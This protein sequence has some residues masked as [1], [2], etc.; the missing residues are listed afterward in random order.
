M[1]K[2]LNIFVSISLIF[3]V[4]CVETE[5]KKERYLIINGESLD[6]SRLSVL[7]DTVD[8]RPLGVENGKKSK[9]L[10]LII[11][12]RLDPPAVEG[13][14]LM[15]TCVS[16]LRGGFVASYNFRGEP[17]HGSLD[18]VNSNLKLHSQVIFNDLDAHAVCVSDAVN[19]KVYIAGASETAEGASLGTISLSGNE[20]FVEDFEEVSLGS[21]AATSV[22]ETDDL[23]FVTTGNDEND[24][25]GLYLFD[26][27][28][29]QLAYEPIHDAR[30]VYA[31]NEQVFVM[32][33]TPGMVYRYRLDTDLQTLTFQTSIAVSG[34]DIPESK[35]TFWVEDDWLFVAGGTEGVHLIDLNS[36]SLINTLTF[37]AEDAI[38]NA[39]AANEDF[40]FISCG[41]AGVYVASYDN[42]GVMETLGILDLA[43]TTSVNHIFEKS[44][45]LYV[46]AGLE[47]L[48]QM[49]IK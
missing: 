43:L 13:E 44:G 49:Q 14:I 6:Q 31:E 33:G 47:G 21:Y 46:A 27:A 17:F 29:N 12:S 38:V 15:A 42:S 10:N 35:S 40:V 48:I 19:R 3:M 16:E 25:G 37:D 41:E 2:L 30:W 39:V 36:N 28:H 5:V 26:L 24:G 22:Y 23:I 34:A 32:Q 20:F 18:Y 11:K 7:N 45:K 9:D 8:L 4:G 1:K